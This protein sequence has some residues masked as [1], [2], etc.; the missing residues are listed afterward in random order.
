[1]NRKQ[2]A[3]KVQQILNRL[4]PD[5]PIPLLH[6]DGYTLLVAVI[7]SAHCTDARV[8]QVT[9]HLFSLAAQPSDMIKLSVE[10]IQQIIHTCGLSHRKANA[11]WQMSHILLEKYEGKVPDRFDALESLPGVGHKT[12]SVIMSQVFHQCAFPVDTHIH[13]LA[14]RWKLSEAKNV[15]ETE[16]DLKELFPKKDWNRLHL[17]IIYFGRQYCQARRHHSSSCP[18]CS[19]I[20]L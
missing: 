6:F 20:P 15:K 13:R 11:I 1:M 17:Q 18:I 3:S 2:I 4:Y 8:N 7:L 12:A 10:E 9:P 19:W 16:K 14:K 5:P